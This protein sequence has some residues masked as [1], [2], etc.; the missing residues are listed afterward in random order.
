MKFPNPIWLLLSTLCLVACSSPPVPSCT[1]GRQELC[2]CSSGFGTQVCTANGTF[3]PC[4]CPI[5]NLGGGSGGGAGGGSAGAG[6]GSAGGAGGGATRVDE[7]VSGTRLRATSWIGAD[8][9]KMSGGAFWDTQLQTY[10]TISSG[11]A[12]VG[13]TYV[14]VPRDL[15][16]PLPLP[17]P[18]GWNYSEGSTC[19][20]PGLLYDLTVPGNI[21]AQPAAASFGLTVSDGG[22]ELVRVTEL[23]LGTV[24]SQGVPSDGG[25]S[26]ATYTG[27]D[28]GFS[29]RFY[30]RTGSASWSELVSGT[31][32]TE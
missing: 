10:C 13:T 21:G 19:S 28:G 29:A 16:L 11:L 17:Y 32:I 22:A 15:C 2:G 14:P 7:L 27:P 8:G 12:V 20:G 18:L 23:A 1:P 5:A 6:G 31:R 24:Y 25:C 4:D 26:L 3:G 9:S 30:R